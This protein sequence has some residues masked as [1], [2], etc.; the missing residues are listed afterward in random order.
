MPSEP[1][2]QP[3]FEPLQF[4]RAEPVNPSA[5]QALVCDRC[6]KPI[7]GV[8]YHDGCKTLCAGCGKV[9]QQMV[10]PD[11]STGTLFR[12]VAFGGGAAIAGALVYYGV[13]AY[14]GLEIGIV[15]IAIG[16]MVGRAIVKATKGR[17]ARRHQI[18][19]V[20]LT[21]LAVALAYAPFAIKEWKDDAK[22]NKIA[23]D[24]VTKA[25]APAT[26][27]TSD[28]SR[29]LSATAAPV[30]GAKKKEPLTL[31]GFVLALL[32]VGG[33]IV[34][35]PVIAALGSMPSGLLSILI[36]GFGLRRAW[37]ITR[38]SNTIVTGPHSIGGAAV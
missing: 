28:T 24:S 7:A 31:R 5:P 14:L 33:L 36:I 12:A 9:R 6:A 20:S 22:S 19:A 21:Y 3:S 35:L 18:L 10:S 37:Q 32:M 11:R 25:P 30:A 34:A 15:A 29:A 26:G 38:A 17:S 23:A 8:Y 1:E 4:D 16:W 27:A 2:V 13:M